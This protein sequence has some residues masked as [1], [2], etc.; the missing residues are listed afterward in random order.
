MATI[1][2][3]C[4]STGKVIPTGMANDQPNWEK[5]AA[6]WKG[7]AFTCPACNTTHAWLKSDAFLDR[8]D[9]RALR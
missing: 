4:A 8:L 9:S 3:K 6:N 7:Q 1:A 5:L 2:I